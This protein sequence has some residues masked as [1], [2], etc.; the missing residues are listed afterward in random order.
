ME[1][2]AENIFNVRELIGNTNATLP[3]FGQIIFEATR[4]YVER[5]QPITLDFSG[6]HQLTESFLKS[7]IGK[8]VSIHPDQDQLVKVKGLG[9]KVWEEDIRSVIQHELSPS[10]VAYSQK[11][12]ND[13]FTD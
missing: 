4:F 6:I 9:H 7:S 8:L 11:R 13:I 1:T 5:N 3:A 12:L 2:T 10:E